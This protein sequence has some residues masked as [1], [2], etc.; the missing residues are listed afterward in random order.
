MATGDCNVTAWE[1]SASLK[2]WQRL[3]PKRQVLGPGLHI[4]KNN[5]NSHLSI[6]GARRATLNMTNSEVNISHE[7]TT[8]VLWI[9]DGI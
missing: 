5:N 6:L 9:Y 7:N 3:K 8:M 1:A 2:F 4:F